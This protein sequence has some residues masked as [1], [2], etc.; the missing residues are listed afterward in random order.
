MESTGLLVIASLFFFRI[1][2]LEF[3]GGL[4]KARSNALDVSCGREK[5]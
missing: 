2:F 5:A 1:R 3:G 4:W